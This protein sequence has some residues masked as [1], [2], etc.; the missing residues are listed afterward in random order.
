MFLIMPSATVENY[1]KCILMLSIENNQS[2]VPMGL[3]ANYLGVTPGTA[4]PGVTPK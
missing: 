3:I 4:V 2:E 1:L